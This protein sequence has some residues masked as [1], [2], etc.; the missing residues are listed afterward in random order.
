V[1]DSNS[2]LIADRRAW[3]RAWGV[4]LAIDEIRAIRWYLEKFRRAWR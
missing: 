4:G 3:Q 1:R 2:A